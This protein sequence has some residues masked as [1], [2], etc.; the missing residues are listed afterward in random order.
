M[1]V[2][3]LDMDEI[4]NFWQHIGGGYYVSVISGFY[5]VDFW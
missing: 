2:K 4:V 1:K 3:A 5:C